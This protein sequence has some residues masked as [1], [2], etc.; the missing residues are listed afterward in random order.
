MAKGKKR[1]HEQDHKK[2]LKRLRR[3]QEKA[4]NKQH[5]SS[6][7]KGNEQS[8]Y[9]IVNGLKAVTLEQ[10]AATKFP[11]REYIIAPWLRNGESALLY[12]TSGLGKSM[13]AMSLAL[14][15]AGGGEFLGWSAPRPRR[16]LFLD[17]EMHIQDIQERTLMLTEALGDTLDRG[18][19]FKNMTLISRQYQGYNVDFPDLNIDGKRDKFFE[20]ATKGFEGAPF[21]L[22][23]LDNLS[24]LATIEDEN[25]SSAF[26]GVIP[27]LMKL[28]QA[29]VACVLVHHTGKS[30]NVNT[31][32]GHSKLATT[33]EV[34]AC[35]QKLEASP[36]LNGAA[37]KLCWDKFRGEK[38]E[39]MTERKAWLAPNGK[40]ENGGRVWEYELLEEEEIKR[41]I[42]TL[43]TLR[44][45][46]QKQLAAALG[47]SESGLSKLKTKA[48]AGGHITR[49]EW[50]HN[51]AEAKKLAEE[52]DM[53][54]EGDEDD[55]H[56]TSQ[57]F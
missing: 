37:F 6:D 40:D 38:S 18:V 9:S 4:K 46:N 12:S 56:L 8:L 35:L 28:K 53:V 3:K 14:A 50:M 54:D 31:F 49:K 17:G 26:N 29:N 44:Y 43:K 16:V 7:N 42:A 21:D 55:K 2:K 47:M 33:F 39:A 22:V 45:T 15:V 19:A 23:I 5:A 20:L 52:E 10:L 34:M 36:V 57:D 30:G 13:F 27:F 51:F 25:S 1:N 48:V 24:T 11:E 41:V 32:R